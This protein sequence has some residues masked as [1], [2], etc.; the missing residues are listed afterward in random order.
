MVA[1]SLHSHVK[2][3]CKNRHHVKID[4]DLHKKFV[5][6]EIGVINQ[7]VQFQLNHKPVELSW[8]VVFSYVTSYIGD[9]CL[10]Y[11]KKNY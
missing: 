8:S 3:N 7:C 9:L 4:A 2:D 10:L 6:L 1:I 5:K 11:H